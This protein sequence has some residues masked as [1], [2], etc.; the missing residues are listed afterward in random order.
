M[1][2]LLV[3]CTHI[4]DKHTDSTQRVQ[5]TST[6]RNTEEIA[7]QAD[8]RKLEEEL[9][10][11]KLTEGLRR[12]LAEKEIWIDE[13]HVR[14]AAL[15]FFEELAGSKELAHIILEESADKGV[16][17]PLAFALVWAES[18]FDPRAVNVNSSSIDRG[19]FQLN[20]RSF[21][22][23]KEAD[24]FDPSINAAHGL[25]YL[26]YCLE[27]GENE[28]V[29]LAMYNA[30]RS[31]VNERGTPKMTLDYI[32]KVLDYRERIES[33]LKTYVAH[34]EGRYIEANT[35]ES[36]AYVVDRKRRTK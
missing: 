29:A 19:L 24:F 6:Q 7:A 31:R 3:T 15:L 25:H 16:P 23:L 5:E 13:P 1:P 8:S 14:D 35:P 30:G 28:V 4:I 26:K 21:P 32:A 10:R 11:Q 2:L 12:Q 27:Y 17:A 18:S 9:S 34:V 33:R 20:S 36:L 22:D